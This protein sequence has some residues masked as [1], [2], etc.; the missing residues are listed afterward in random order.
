MVFLTSPL[1]QT[2]IVLAL[3]GII[4]ALMAQKKGRRTFRWWLFGF[5]LP[6]VAIPTIFLAEDLNDK[7][8]SQ[9]AERIRRGALRCRYCGYEYRALDDNWRIY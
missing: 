5:I 2:L 3:F 6:V 4:P 7:K 8:C 1:L 9:C